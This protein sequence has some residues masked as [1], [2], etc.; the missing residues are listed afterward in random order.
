LAVAGQRDGTGSR[1]HNYA[2]AVGDGSLQGGHYISYHK[3][4]AA[5]QGLQCVLNEVVHFPAAH[6]GD[7]RHGSRQLRGR[8][9]GMR[10]SAENR[11]MKRFA[12][13]GLA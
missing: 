6:T 1:D 3:N 2:G 13:S 7:T 4:L 5:N 11:L 10:A 9:L 12:S 8:D